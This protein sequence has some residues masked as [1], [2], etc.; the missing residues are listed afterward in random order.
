MQKYFSDLS[1]KNHHKNSALK[2]NKGIKQPASFHPDAQGLFKKTKPQNLEV[3]D[4]VD[5]IKKGN[6][7]ILSKAIT[8]IESSLSKHQELA[9][10]IVEQCLPYS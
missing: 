10:E 3:E 1:D 4:Y 9:R 7:T 2:V 5:G 6:R 8:L